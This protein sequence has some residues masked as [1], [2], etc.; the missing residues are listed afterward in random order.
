MRRSGIIHAKFDDQ[1]LQTVGEFTLSL[2]RTKKQ[3]LIASGEVIGY[4]E[5]LEDPPSIKGSIAIDKNTDFNRL[6]ESDGATITLELGEQVFVLRSAWLAE[7]ELTTD[8]GK[9]N[10]TFQGKSMEV[11]R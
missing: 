5:V 9:M 11:V 2:G 3:A 10:V 7:H 6:F 8:E 1:V 4:K